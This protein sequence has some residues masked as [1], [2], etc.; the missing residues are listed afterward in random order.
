MALGNY[1]ENETK[2]HYGDVL[3]LSKKNLSCPEYGVSKIL[4]NVPIPNYANARR[5]IPDAVTLI[6]TTA[7]TVF[8]NIPYSITVPYFSCSLFLFTRITLSL[9]TTSQ[10]RNIMRDHWMSW[11]FTEGSA[12][13]TGLVCEPVTCPKNVTVFHLSQYYLL[14][15]ASTLFCRVSI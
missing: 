3:L 9:N 2:F 12:V 14:N 5:H 6:M 8:A 4:R 13:L 7:F 11:H 10:N 1:N 15:N